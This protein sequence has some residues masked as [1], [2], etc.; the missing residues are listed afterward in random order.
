MTKK[1]SAQQVPF[2]ILY[3]HSFLLVHGFFISFRNY[4]VYY[5]YRAG[6]MRNADAVAIAADN[7]TADL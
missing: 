7:P 2:N 1:A 4:L 6:A 3:K 5:L